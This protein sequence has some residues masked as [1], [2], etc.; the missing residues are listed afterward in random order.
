MKGS[1]GARGGRWATIQADRFSLGID[2]THEAGN[3]AVEAKPGQGAQLVRPGQSSRKGSAVT[4]QEM[5]AVFRLLPGQALAQTFHGNGAVLETALGED[6]HFKAGEGFDTAADDFALEAVELL[7][8]II[9][10]RDERDALGLL[11][12]ARAG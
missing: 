1:A 2:G 7:D 3:G 11:D 10:E 4:G 5:L 6:R 9:R 12:D 8:V